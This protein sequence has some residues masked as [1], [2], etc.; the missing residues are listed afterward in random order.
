MTSTGNA[1]RTA[2]APTITP[3][4]HRERE[5]MIARRDIARLRKVID[6]IEATQDT[7][8]PRWTD[9]IARHATTISRNEVR[10]KELHSMGEA[11]L[12]EDIARHYAA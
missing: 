12:R 6:K 9:A 10:I 11:E 5:L 2:E 1:D 8:E 7:T 4:R 3:A